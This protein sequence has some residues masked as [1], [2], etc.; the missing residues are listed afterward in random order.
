MGKRE[1]GVERM[2]REKKTK[3]GMRERGSV[4]V[5]VGAVVWG[6]WEGGFV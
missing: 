2:E 3:S 1:R 5:V 4:G 6:V